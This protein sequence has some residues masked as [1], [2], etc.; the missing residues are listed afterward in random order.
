[1]VETGSEQVSNSDLFLV[2]TSSSLLC[3]DVKVTLIVIVG[4]LI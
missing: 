3:P 2:V 1:M 4:T